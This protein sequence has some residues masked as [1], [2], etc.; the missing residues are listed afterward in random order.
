VQAGWR[1]VAPGEAQRRAMLADILELGSHKAVGYLPL[2]T[3][4]AHLGVA[5]RAVTA[6]AGRRGLH[7]LRL[8]SR[9]TC[10][11][12]GARYV[13]HR[14]AP[15]H[16]LRAS[17]RVPRRYRLPRDPDRFV[18]AIAARWFPP[19]HPVCG[20]IARTFGDPFTRHTTRQ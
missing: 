7:T 19:A 3:L 6:E 4:T 15:A 9:E 8:A 10:I 18:R 5:P 11:A 16:L 17:A 20:S 2:R 14:R 12:S 1:I 13:H